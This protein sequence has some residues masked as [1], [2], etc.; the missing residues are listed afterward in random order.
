MMHAKFAPPK[1]LS[2]LHETLAEIARVKLTGG[3]PRFTTDIYGTPQSGKAW[4]DLYD[5][6]DAYWKEHHSELDA[7][8]DRRLLS[9]I[10]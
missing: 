9:G 7:K 6:I 2:A 10:I 8:P 4:L 1:S 3:V 5:K